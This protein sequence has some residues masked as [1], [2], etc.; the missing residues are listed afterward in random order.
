MLLFFSTHLERRKLLFDWCKVECSSD[1]VVVEVGECNL[2][3]TFKVLRQSSSFEP[4][5]NLLGGRKSFIVKV[6]DL[7]KTEWAVMLRVK[8]KL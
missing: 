1:V 5:L 8:S 4:F 6:V 7:D 2:N 3:D